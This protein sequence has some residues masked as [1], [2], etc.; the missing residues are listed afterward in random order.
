MCEL[1]TTGFVRRHTPYPDLDGLLLAGR[2]D[3]PALH[4]LGGQPLR[5]WDQFIRTTT[6]HAG[7]NALLREAGAEWLMR[8]IGIVVDD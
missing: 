4:R 7:W 3:A 8:R 1:L 5:D 6:R 2:V